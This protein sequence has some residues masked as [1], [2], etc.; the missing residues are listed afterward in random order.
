M[1]AILGTNTSIYHVH[2]W[3]NAHMVVGDVMYCIYHIDEVM[4]AVVWGGDGLGVKLAAGIP[5]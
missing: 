4:I 3:Y 1:G 5:H 2:I